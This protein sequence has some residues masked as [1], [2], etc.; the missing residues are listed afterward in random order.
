MAQPTDYNGK[1]VT[2]SFDRKIDM[3]EWEAQVRIRRQRVRAGLEIILEEMTFR[4]FVMLPGGWLARRKKGKRSTWLPEE[5]KINSF[6]LGLLGDKK[7]NRITKK[8]LESG[9]ELLRTRDLAPATLNRHR[10]LLHTIWRDAKDSEP[11]IVLTNPVAAIPLLKEKNKVNPHG[12][13]DQDGMVKYLA[14]I[15]AFGLQWV[16]WAALQMFPGGRVD[17]VLVL[18]WK[19][20]SWEG[21]A[22]LVERIWEIS[23]K[24]IVKRT[25][26]NRGESDQLE[27]LI[28]LDE[29]MVYLRKWFGMTKWNRPND[30]IVCDPR[31]GKYY[32]Y[33]QAKRI[34]D[35]VVEQAGLPKVTPHGL[36]HTAGRYLR[37]LGFQG[38]DLKGLMRHKDLKTTEGYSPIDLNYLVSRVERARKEGLKDE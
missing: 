26:G 14:A 34:H 12:Y 4:D 16:V 19:D 24:E 7:M 20:V 37:R 28:I 11:P 27:H 13:L 23:S 2:R 25:K 38:D 32:T 31:T 9:F 17:E 3:L 22:I 1:T 30:F 5:Q 18:K 15:E 21:R 36:R 6:W 8:E 33:W 35:L 10:S 29:L